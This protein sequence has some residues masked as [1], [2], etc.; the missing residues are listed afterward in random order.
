MARKFGPTAQKRHKEQKRQ[1]KQQAKAARRLEAKQRKA[2]GAPGEDESDLAG[3]EPFDSP[4][5]TDG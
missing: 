3:S 4:M 1:Q 2:N 5:R